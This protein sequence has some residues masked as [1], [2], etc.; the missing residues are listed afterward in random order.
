MFGYYCDVVADVGGG[1]DSVPESDHESR[2]AGCF[3]VAGSVESVDH[4]CGVDGLAV[5]VE[6]VHRVEDG[7]VGGYLE[8]GGCE[9]VEGFVGGGLRAEQ[10]ADH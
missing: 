10:G 1:G 4:C 3:E 6:V 9:L 2:A 5:V 7:A 8:V